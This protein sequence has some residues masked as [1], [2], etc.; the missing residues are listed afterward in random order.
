MLQGIQLMIMIVESAFAIPDVCSSAVVIQF[1]VYYVH[2]ACSTGN[3]VYVQAYKA[4]ENLPVRF[5]P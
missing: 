3:T 4:E 1:V 5:K 2:L